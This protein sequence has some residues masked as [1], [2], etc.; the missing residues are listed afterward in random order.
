[1]LAEYIGRPY[2]VLRALAVAAGGMVLVNPFIL[3][4]DP[5]F[6]L[7]FM[8]T[9]GLL[10]GAPILDKPFSFVTER[11]GL[12]AIVSATFAT[13]LAVLPLLLFQLGS[14]SLVAP[15]VNLLVLPLV[16]LVMAVG[17][18][19]GMIGMAST[20]LAVPFS[21]IAHAILF[22]M[23]QVVWYF[24]TLPFASIALP[25]VSFLLVV[26]YYGLCIA[27]LFYVRTRPAAAGRV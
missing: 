21:W 13:Q 16:S 26:A 4:F 12:R 11:L 23:F 6:Q 17:F 25:P 27:V 10:L 24:G 2:A 15:F 20:L 3:V 9:L 8:A 18:A 5:G 22:Y 1:M 14:V 7:S 19:A